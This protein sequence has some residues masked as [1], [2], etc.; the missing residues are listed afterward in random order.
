L[1]SSSIS[2]GLTTATGLHLC[3]QELHV[4]DTP[5]SAASRCHLFDR[6]SSVLIEWSGAWVLCL[7]P[8]D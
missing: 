1:A 4:R 8:V 2:D 5:G 7:G 3:A 6:W